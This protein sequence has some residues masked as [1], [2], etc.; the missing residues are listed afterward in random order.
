MSNPYIPSDITTLSMMGAPDKIDQIASQ[1][2]NEVRE[3]SITFV[4]EYFKISALDLLGTG[5]KGLQARPNISLTTAED[6]L[7]VAASLTDFN[8]RRLCSKADAQRMAPLAEAYPKELQSMWE[9]LQHKGFGIALLNV[10]TIMAIKAR[11]PEILP[12]NRI[13][14]NAVITQPGCKQ[15]IREGDYNQPIENYFVPFPIPEWHD[16]DHLVSTEIDDRFSTDLRTIQR[17]PNKYTQLNSADPNYLVYLAPD[18]MTKFPMDSDYG[19]FQR[20]APWFYRR[21]LLRGM[22]VEE[23]INYVQ[24]GL[25]GFLCRNEPAGDFRTSKKLFLPEFSH[26]YNAQKRASLVWGSYGEVPSKEVS[27]YITFLDKEE[28]G[29]TA[30]LVNSDEKIAKSAVHI[31]FTIAEHE[32]SPPTARRLLTELAFAR[33]SMISAKYSLSEAKALDPELENIL[34]N[35]MDAYD[36][37]NP[38]SK[39]EHPAIALR[40]WAEWYENNS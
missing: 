21:A 23:T 10:S 22:D 11:N 32:K 28:P 33:A 31:L 13:A 9:V 1:I 39:G 34:T 2:K 20:I 19:I 5:P 4:R 25:V 36:F 15:A 18:D 3:N 40:R 6:L 7:K 30:G 8:G 17:I 27:P 35:F 37:E 14:R 16:F 26:E 29:L 12:R 24:E 38:E